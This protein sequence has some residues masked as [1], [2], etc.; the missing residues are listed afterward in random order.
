M[1]CNKISK[2][3]NYRERPM[4]KFQ[5]DVSTP[6]V[7]LKIALRW[8]LCVYR[9]FIKEYFRLNLYQASREESVGMGLRTFY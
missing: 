2:T 4:I 5:R 8:K 7:F 3:H 1:S 9:N 6:Y